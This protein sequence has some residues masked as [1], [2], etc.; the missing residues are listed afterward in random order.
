LQASVVPSA[1]STGDDDNA[2][3][4]PINGLY[5]TEL[6]RKKGPRET[7]EAME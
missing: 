3:A 7:V 2:L 6:V 1:G 4:E 5:E